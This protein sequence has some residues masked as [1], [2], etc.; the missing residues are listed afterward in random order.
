MTLAG[1]SL[2]LFTMGATGARGQVI[3]S[4]HFTGTFTLPFEAQWGAMTL[5]SG[6]YTLQYGTQDNGHGLVVVRG[7][8]KGSPYGMILAGPVGDVSATR[9]AIVCVRKGN[10][11]L[12]R[13]LEM[14]AIGES[15]AFRMPRGVR[16]MANRRNGRTNTRPAEASTLIQ[17]VP[18]RL[19]EK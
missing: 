12:V 18:V 9:N 16:L 11:L 8:A 15:V 10:A 17:L 19:N 13:A 1:L 4:T 5:P 7:T 6:D 2:V 3:Y 14:P